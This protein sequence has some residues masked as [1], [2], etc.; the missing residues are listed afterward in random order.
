MTERTRSMIL[1]LDQSPE[2][3]RKVSQMMRALSHPDRLMIVD[4]LFA[5]G[6]LPVS[7]LAAELGLSQSQTSQHLRKLETLGYLWAE[8][9]GKQIYYSVRHAGLKQL[10]KCLQVCTEC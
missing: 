7:E 5:Q 6:P 3:M 10:L 1:G 4:F 9:S 2:R 8:R